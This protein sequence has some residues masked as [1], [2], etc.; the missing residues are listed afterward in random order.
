MSLIANSN[1]RHWI[2]LITKIISLIFKNQHVEVMSKQFIK[3]NETITFDSSDDTE[4]NTSSQ[5]LVINIIFTL[6][7]LKAVCF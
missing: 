6:R 1:R 4:S 2:V 7:L 5:N 3:M